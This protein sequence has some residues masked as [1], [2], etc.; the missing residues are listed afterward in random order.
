MADDKKLNVEITGTDNLSPLTKQLL[1]SVDKLSG[2]LLT[3]GKIF[4]KVD[5]SALDYAQSSTMAAAKTILHTASTKEL[6]TAVSE[7]ISYLARYRKAL[8]PVG[9]ATVKVAS[10]TET[11]GEIMARTSKNMGANAELGAAQAN[12]AIQSEMTVLTEFIKLEEL[13][14]IKAS[15]DQKAATA[16][17]IEGVSSRNKIRKEETLKSKEAF[18][19]TSGNKSSN[20]GANIYSSGEETSRSIKPPKENL[21][22]DVGKLTTAEV[23]LNSV[24]KE[25]V[26]VGKASN[27]A[28]REIRHAVAIIDELAR[29]QKGAMISS[30]GAGLRDAGLSAIGLMT[31]M[32]G[33]VAVMAA[34]SGTKA[35]EES[36]KLAETQTAAAEAAGMTYAQ[37]N[38]LAAT[39]GL[40]GLKEDEADRALKTLSKSFVEG[41]A[42]PVGKAGK[43]LTAFGFSLSE[44]KSAVNDPIE[45]LKLLADHWNSFAN[46]EERARWLNDLTGMSMAKI[47]PLLDKMREGLNKNEAEA[48]AAGA[49]SEEYSK[50][51]KETGE[52]LEHMSM[53]SIGNLHKAFLDLK[54]TIDASIGSFETFTT[55]MGNTGREAV[56]LTGNFINLFKSLGS[57]NLEAAGGYFQN[58]DTYLVNLGIR[59]SNTL[60]TMIGINA[61]A[62]L[63]GDQGKNLD[64]KPESADMQL[65]HKNLDA[66]TT[67]SKI[68]PS[69]PGYSS[70]KSSGDVS[71][72]AELNNEV[73]R[74]QELDIKELGDNPSSHDI[75]MT[76][77]RS[78]ISTLESAQKDARTKSGNYGKTEL[79]A[80][81]DT[82]GN[83][84]VQDNAARKAVSDANLSAISTQLIKER[85]ELKKKE[86]EEQE[87]SNKAGEVAEKHAQKQAEMAQRK[88][89]AQAK[90]E[91]PTAL[92]TL[93]LNTQIAETKALSNAWDA[94]KNSKH[95]TS[96]DEEIDL[97]KVKIDSLKDKLVEL[98]AE[99][100][101]DVTPKLFTR[102]RTEIEKTSAEIS[103]AN[104]S[105]RHK[106]DSEENKSAKEASVEADKVSEDKPKLMTSQTEVEASREDF[107]NVNSGKTESIQQQIDRQ[108]RLYADTLASSNQ[109]ISRQQKIMN[110][111]SID[112]S[113]SKFIEA[114]I[115]KNEA[116]KKTL[117]T[118][119]EVQKT[120]NDLSG[121]N[122]NDF[123]APLATGLQ[124]V[125]TTFDNQL[126]STAASMFSTAMNPQIEYIHRGLGTIKVNMQSQ[127]LRAEAHKLFMSLASSM[128]ESV[129]SGIS[130][131]AAKQMASGFF[132]MIGA[133]AG[134]TLKEGSGIGGMLSQGIG[135]LFGSGTGPAA[136]AAAGAAPAVNLV[137]VT[138]AITAAGAAQVGA[139]GAAAASNVGVTTAVGTTQ[140]AAT[141]TSGALQVAA[142]AVWGGL[143]V[144]ATTIWGGIQSAATGLWGGLQVA[145]TW[146]VE[147]A[148]ALWGAINALILKPLGFDEGGI[149]PS[150][151]G[152]MVNDGKG[153]RLSILHPKE[154]VLPAHISTAFQSMIA[155]GNINVPSMAGGG[156][157]TPSAITGAISPASWA[158]KANTGQ[159]LSTENP[160]NS[161]SMGAQNMP[162]APKKK[163]EK[164]YDTVLDI[165]KDAGGGS[166]KGLTGQLTAGFSEKGLEKQLPRNWGDVYGLKSLGETM[167]S[168]N[169][170]SLISQGGHNAELGF[171][172]A[173]K[174]MSPQMSSV[175]SA[176]GG[177]IANDNGNLSGG[178]GGAGDGIM[179]ILHPNEMV[180]PASISNSIQNMSRGGSNSNSQGNIAHTT[181]SNSA[182][183]SYSPTINMQ[184]RMSQAEFSGMLMS[185]SSSLIGNVRNMIRNGWRP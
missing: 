44:I 69:I 108:K 33:L 48:K 56:T 148:V 104:L 65:A 66:Q 162:V 125:G 168:G 38:I 120:L 149:V 6:N 161:S 60:N 47:I 53:V 40:M 136:G 100:S 122:F 61:Q 134:T 135:S 90:R 97:T 124:S 17:L 78:K 156:I 179:S 46:N 41:L 51:I 32:G 174:Y 82:G 140:A 121:K 92:E 164:W 29:G 94:V 165:A 159:G 130:Q 27:I 24:E 181:N 171:N 157:A 113:S 31:G 95:D 36:A 172:D 87:K 154:M 5:K 116:E 107:S 74:N 10:V 160:I 34:Y 64:V 86:A 16:A 39:L 88:A 84:K 26:R 68:K 58:I 118:L 62:T 30:L 18:A 80:G 182:N 177:M 72:S 77:L 147:A 109:E 73:A 76:K 129:A 102:I 75:M 128:V 67:P 59:A 85:I 23:K 137:P 37:Y 3:A 167:P 2:G 21:S 151:A 115:A 42:D 152:G 178:L 155:K 133:P 70:K 103:R 98:Q 131:L 141:T 145:A 9:Q 28:A 176:A 63:K 146:G 184:G 8:D 22:W 93:D 132:N 19:F 57:G 91:A 81:E 45:G 180:L 111:P 170:A 114:E 1:N 11:A 138:A 119:T 185:H 169:L 79:D 183:M 143:Q 12:K 49:G 126:G 35:I 139:T 89:E 142:H 123:L 106:Q 14:G 50:A 55:I 15:E 96:G 153:G 112:K 173:M 71:F 43:A 110:D 127:Q 117:D 20:H 166:F 54:P 83:T 163:K 4:D 101:K 52:K 99:L 158:G 175:P 105:L 144:T 13:A 25:F 7:T 150:A